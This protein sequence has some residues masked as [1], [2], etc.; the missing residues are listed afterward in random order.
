[1]KAAAKAYKDNRPFGIIMAR[2][3]SMVGVVASV[4]LTKKLVVRIL[5]LPEVQKE[6]SVADM[7]FDMTPRDLAVDGVWCGKDRIEVDVFF[8]CRGRPETSEP[9]KPRWKNTWLQGWVEVR[10]NQNG[11]LDL[12]KDSDSV[13]VEITEDDDDLVTPAGKRICQT[14]LSCRQVLRDLLNQQAG[15]DD[16]KNDE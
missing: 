10:W 6:A 14:T 16:E 4:V 12:N 15:G 3:N 7:A 9:L 2:W 5:E 11:S 8:K 13:F 1:M